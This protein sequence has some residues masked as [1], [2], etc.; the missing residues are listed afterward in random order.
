MAKSL[1]ALFLKAF[2]PCPRLEK[3]R[4]TTVE[5]TGRTFSAKD[6]SRDRILL[7]VPIGVSQKYVPVHGLALH[8]FRRSTGPADSI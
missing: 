3:T 7:L 5:K 6:K 4:Q 1:L 8:R 2:T